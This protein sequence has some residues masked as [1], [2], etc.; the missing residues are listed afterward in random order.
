MNKFEKA[1]HSVISEMNE[2]IMKQ[3]GFQQQVNDVHNGICPFCKTPINMDEF[4]DQLS[5]K[6][7]KISG[8]CQKCQ[9]QVFGSFQEGENDFEDEYAYQKA[10]N[11]FPQLRKRINNKIDNDRTN[12]FVR[13]FAAAVANYASDKGLSEVFEM[14]TDVADLSSRDEILSAI[15]NGQHEIQEAFGTT[16]ASYLP[17]Q[18]LEQVYR[19]NL[20][21]FEDDDQLYNEDYSFYSPMSPSDI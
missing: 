7:Y 21:L 14:M 13:D 17:D 1:Y 10:A 18:D 2:Q 16:A 11:F 3:M 5:K 6:E 15:N 8:L 19:N 9:D 12:S 20:D 4:R